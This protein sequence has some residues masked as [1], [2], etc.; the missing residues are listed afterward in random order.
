M[1]EKRTTR[2]G[3]VTMRST[4]LAL[5]CCLGS[6]E[7]TQFL[8][9]ELLESTLLEFWGVIPESTPKILTF[10]YVN[11]LSL[12][13]DNKLTLNPLFGGVMQESESQICGIVLTL[14]FVFG[15]ICQRC[16]V[17]LLNIMH[18]TNFCGFITTYN[19]LW[20]PKNSKSINQFDVILFARAVTCESMHGEFKTLYSSS[21]FVGNSPYTVLPGYCDNIYCD[22][23][24][25]MTVLRNE[26]FIL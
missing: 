16:Q 26:N 17:D 12:S 10:Y 20:Y 3:K 19:F 6:L 21:C 2:I 15:R 9:L 13:Y 1:S 7:L 4:A 25:I 5:L 18:I 11:F 22:K 24:L 14:L 8:V 23:L